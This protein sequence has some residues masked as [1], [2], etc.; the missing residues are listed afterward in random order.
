LHTISKN[1]KKIIFLIRSYNDFDCRLPL[2][3]EFINKGYNIDVKIIPTNNGIFSHEEA[4]LQ[5]SLEKYNI[6][7]T[8]IFNSLKKF[9][10]IR[11]IFFLYKKINYEKFPQL[12]KH[13][14]KRIKYFIFKIIV[15]YSIKNNNWYKNI[16]LSFYNSIVIIDEI[17]F[18][19]NRSFFVDELFNH[20][21][22]L[23]IYSF[24][25]GQD[26]YINL[27]HDEGQ[28]VLFDSQFKTNIPLFTPSENDRRINQNNFPEEKV[29]TVGNTRFDSGWVKKL[30]TEAKKDINNGEQLLKMPY[31]KKIIFMLSKIEYGVDLE[32]I[33]EVINNCAKMNNSL[34]ILKPHTRGMKIDTWRN[35]LN[36]AVI[37]GSRFSSSVLIEW[38]HTVLFTG[39][40]IIFQPMIMHK[41]VVFLK[42]C[43]K[44]ETIFDNISSICV[45]ESLMDAIEYIENRP[46][47]LI[48][49][50][51]LDEFVRVNTHNGLNNGSVCKSVV[52][53]IEKMENKT[54]V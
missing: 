50:K 29:I 47:K 38:S 31:R 37:D 22:K 12:L 13:K 28:T 14:I 43:Q 18:Q 3:I 49:T 20:K 34:V 8:S 42:Y 24:L 45:A 36:P 51:E 26:T 21:D 17:V 33:I 32:N 23:S 35:K 10:I 19:K 41:K 39:S 6:T 9:M 46:I 44:Y 40:S 54:I 15:S 25:T 16:I 11:S 30:S 7:I 27:W 52:S 53:F 48:D 2:M 5:K 4:K 1:K